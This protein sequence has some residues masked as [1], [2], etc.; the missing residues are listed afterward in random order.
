MTY[1]THSWSCGG[2]IHA[3]PRGCDT[4]H[5]VGGVAVGERMR[6]FACVTCV[7]HAEGRV[8]EGDRGC[9]VVQRQWTGGFPFHVAQH[10]LH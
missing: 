7:M 3:T 1:V 9:H 10:D 2:V 8:L 6:P 4:W 5:T